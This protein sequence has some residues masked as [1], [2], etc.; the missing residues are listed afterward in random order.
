MMTGSPPRFDQIYVAFEPR[1]RR[2][3]TRLVGENE[4]Q[5]L[6][7]E[8]FFKVSQGL[9]NFRGESK[10]ATWIYRIARNTALDRVRSPAFQDSAKQALLNG[11]AM[12]EAEPSIEQQ[13][14][15]REMN[16][17]IRGLIEELPANYRSVLVLGELIELTD[18]QIAERLEISLPAV[19]VRLHRGRKRIRAELE[20]HCNFSR[21]PQNGLACEPKCALG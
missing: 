20:K 3:L 18:H 1:I 2:Y 9:S 10:L 16:E 6:T 11:V 21:S 5:D 8:V 19:K 13:L 7:Q 14:I 4:A 17:C 12:E 15:R